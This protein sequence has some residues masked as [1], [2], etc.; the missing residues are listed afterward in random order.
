MPTSKSNISRQSKSVPEETRKRGRNKTSVK[1]KVRN[2]KGHSGNKWNRKYKT[3][4]LIK[5]RAGFRNNK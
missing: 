4:S 1:Q 2:N 5:L 3:K